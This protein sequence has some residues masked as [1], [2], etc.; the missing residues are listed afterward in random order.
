MGFAPADSI[1]SIVLT[2][3]PG[4]LKFLS[5]FLTRRRVG[6]NCPVL[7]I[8]RFVNRLIVLFG[9]GW[10]GFGRSLILWTKCISL[11][12]T[13][14]KK[15]WSLIHSV[16]KLWAGKQIFR[17]KNKYLGRCKNS[18]KFCLIY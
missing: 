3:N 8:C 7:I 14:L 15:I 5:R 4:G 2:V 12:H 1:S 10:S 11:I 6:W 16:S 17:S 13:N 18:I 9:I